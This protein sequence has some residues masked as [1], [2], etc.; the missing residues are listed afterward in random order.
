MPQAPLRP[1]G[2]EASTIAGSQSGN[3]AIGRLMSLDGGQ[4]VRGARRMLL[5]VPRS[6][7]GD[8]LMRLARR[9]AVSSLTG[10][11]ALRL[12]SHAAEPQLWRP[13][14]QADGEWD[15]KTLPP[16]EDDEPEVPVDGTNEL[17]GNCP[18]HLS[19]ESTRGAAATAAGS[20]SDRGP[21][22]QERR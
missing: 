20:G 22:H 10:A 9:P 11:D 15:G 21:P 3:S 8:Q 17:V 16:E 7:R 1:I 12:S 18:Q 6:A 2:C 5:S 19:G 4:A 13:D 14:L